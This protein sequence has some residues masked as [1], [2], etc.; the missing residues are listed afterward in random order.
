MTRKAYNKM[1]DREQRAHCKQVIC[2]VVEI[3]NSVN[4]TRSNSRISAS[5]NGVNARFFR[6][7][8]TSLRG[9][10]TSFV[11]GLKRE[12][13]ARV[14]AAIGISHGS[15]L[16]TN[17]DITAQFC[18]MEN[19]IDVHDLLGKEPTPEERKKIPYHFKSHIIRAVRALRHFGYVKGAK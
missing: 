13:T 14:R 1:S 7:L 9:P 4:F 15:G 16:M 8:I 18:A 10:D 3:I 19:R 6:D 11:S 12:T 17:T 2:D 5:A